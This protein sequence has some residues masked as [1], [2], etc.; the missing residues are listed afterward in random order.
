MRRFLCA[1]SIACCAL[2]S[3]E[4]DA[5]CEVEASVFPGEVVCGDCAT[6]A[7]SGRGQGLQVFGENFNSGTPVGWSFTQQARFDNPCSISG[8]DG[9]THIWMGNTSAVPRSLETL[10][11]NFSSATSGGTVCFDMLFSVQGNAAPCEGPDEPDEGVYLQ[12]STDGV[13]WITIQY[14][15]P[16]GGNDPLLI[17]WN[18]WCFQLPPAALTDSTQIRWFQDNDSGADYDHWGIDNVEIF[19][20]DPTYEIVWLHDGY[21]YGAGSSGGLNPKPACPQQTTDYVV[22]M[23]NGSQTC[24]DTVRVNVV[25]PQLVVNAGPDIR[26][27]EGECATINATAKVIKRPAKTP[28]YANAEVTQIANTLGTSTTIGINITDLNITSVQ[29]NSITQVCITGLSFFGFNLFPPAQQTIGDLNIYLVCPDGTRILLIPSGQTTSLTPLDGYTNTCFTPAATNDISLASPPYTGTFAS[30]EPLSNLAG[31]TANG[32]WQIE[33]APT[34]ATGIGVGFFNGWSIS[35]NDP[36]ISYTAE[37]SWN[38]VTG[39]SDTNSLQ[40]VVCPTQD[41]TY[42][43]TASDTA[44]CVTTSDAVNVSVDTTNLNIT[45]T[46]T[47][48]DC[49][50]TD[51]GINITVTGGSGSYTYLWSNGAITQDLTAVGAGVYSV[52]VTDP[53]HCQEDTLFNLSTANGP[54]INSITP[55]A[56]T[57]FGLN[58]GSAVV[59]ATGGTGT[60]TYVWSDGQTTATA[61]G[62]TPGT[63]T[64]TVSDA[65]SCESV[66]IAIV[67]A[68]AN[69]I[70]SF[71]ATDETCFN[72]CDGTI[73]VSA[74]GGTGTLDYAWSDGNATTSARTGLCA[75]T[76]GFTV[77]D[78]N[79]CTESGSVD[80]LSAGALF[81]NLGSDLT[82]CDGLSVTL[83]AGTGFAQYAWSTNETTQTIEVTQSGDYSVTVTSGMCSASDTVNVSVIPAPVININ[84]SDTTITIGNGVALTTTVSGTANGNYFWTPS[85]YLSCDDCAAPVATP[86][87]EGDYVYTVNYY[88][89][90][91]CAGSDSVLIKVLPENFTPVVPSA[92]TPDGLGGNNTI[93]VLP[94]GIAV[95]EFRVYNRWGQEVHNATV[96]WDGT[97]EGKEQPV[98]TFSYYAVVQLPDGKEQRL[99]GVFSLLR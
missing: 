54:T 11:Y 64:V 19:Y 60:L 85:I 25:A 33:V 7:A 14:F 15:D 42:T 9:T 10:P 17:N 88:D 1:I 3:L 32:V 30:G 63:Y 78:A 93:Y 81:V 83:D 80:V 8:V 18:N 46:L 35:F 97:F 6:L 47:N 65:L 51:G 4:V 20:N 31:C 21:N 5:Q 95:K 91:E 40:P 43:L 73:S 16:N 13:N 28:T 74:S 98:G 59:S 82:F 55:T 56:E 2:I 26:V 34:T 37:L 38:P 79:N 86:T 39:L 50:A 57:C 77:S 96:A 53:A 92:F 22:V 62:L 36:E 90:Q 41:I 75:A 24:S 66:A 27:C 49:G 87:P 45:A 69:I 58:N 23:S 76:Y 72:A 89:E 67:G 61:T 71:T 44:G 52:T 84:P 94:A 12:Y 29:P 68:G 48:P 99:S 70:A